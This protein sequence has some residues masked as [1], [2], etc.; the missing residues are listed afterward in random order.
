MGK[1]G[2]AIDTV[3]DQPSHDELTWD[4]EMDERLVAEAVALHLYREGLCDLADEYVASKGLDDVVEMEIDETDVVDGR[5]EG[6]DGAEPS[7]S[8]RPG[9]EPPSTPSRTP[10]S[11]R[12]RSGE[13]YAHSGTNS[14]ASPAP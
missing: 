5:A 4:H 10:R 11:R 6:A 9:S 2:K 8:E 14:D 3:F 7:G 1:L 12:R 13:N